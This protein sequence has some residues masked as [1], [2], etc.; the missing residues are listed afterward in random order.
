M[1]LT[2]FANPLQLNCMSNLVKKS[3]DDALI[4]KPYLQAAL[5]QATVDIMT[6][7]I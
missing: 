1:L 6:F 7:N 2:K 5:I 3:S 4:K